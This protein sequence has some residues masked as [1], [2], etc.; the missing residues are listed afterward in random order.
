LSAI[1]KLPACRQFSRPFPCPPESLRYRRSG[2]GVNVAPRLAK[3]RA[4]KHGMM[5][6]QLTGRIRLVPSAEGAA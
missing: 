5:Q 2:Q 3:A 4:I 6:E 1:R